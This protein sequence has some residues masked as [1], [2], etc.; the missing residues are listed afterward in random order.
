MLGVASGS[1]A[2]P[3]EDKAGRGGAHGRA[4]VRVRA[5]PRA[6]QRVRRRLS[7]SRHGVALFK[8]LYISLNRGWIDRF[9]VEKTPN[10]RAN[11]HLDYD[12]TIATSRLRRGTS[13][14]AEAPST[15]SPTKKFPY[16]PYPLPPYL[17][18][19]F[20]PSH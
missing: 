10:E 3:V 15:T 4:R 13:E 8:R 12:A 14:E 2:W 18:L 17:E 9:L 7:A 6:R 1:L 16:P 20:V 19:L 5:G 11:E